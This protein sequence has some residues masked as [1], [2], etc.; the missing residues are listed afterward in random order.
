MLLDT[1]HT[2]SFSTPSWALSCRLQFVIRFSEQC[3]WRF[4]SSAMWC[5]VIWQVIPNKNSSWA[6][7]S[8]TWRHYSPS[9]CWHLQGQWHSVT[10]QKTRLYVFPLPCFIFLNTHISDLLSQL[11][12]FYTWN[13]FTYIFYLSR[14]NTDMLHWVVQGHYFTLQLTSL[15]PPKHFIW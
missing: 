6:A 7:W 1:R 12:R 5:C 3:C 15:F 10:S 8:W 11:L 9:K 4:K 2:F 14:T 13:L